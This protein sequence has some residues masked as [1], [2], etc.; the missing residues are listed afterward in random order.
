MG[1]VVRGP[2]AD[3]SAWCQPSLWLKI[4][5]IDR[6]GAPG[7]NRDRTR[8]V[9][10]SANFGP[11]GSLSLEKDACRIK[12]RSGFFRPG[13]LSRSGNETEVGA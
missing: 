3:P 11:S 8:R 5:K 2:P 13:F 6:E 4:N 1:G 12:M 9:I 10:L 7:V